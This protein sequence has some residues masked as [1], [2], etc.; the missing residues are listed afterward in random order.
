MHKCGLCCL[1]LSVYPSICHVL[2]LYSWLKIS[3]NLFLDLVAHHSSIWPHAAVY[4]PVP[5]SKG[6]FFS[7]SVKY[8]GGWEKFAIFDWKC[9]LTWKRYLIGPGGES[10]RINSNDLEWPWKREVRVKYFRQISL[11]MLIAFDLRPNRTG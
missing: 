6:N 2:I 8:T 9:R 11:M 1:L 4:A 10:I 5:N 7:G 3:S